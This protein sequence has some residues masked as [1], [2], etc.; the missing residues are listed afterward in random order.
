MNSPGNPNSEA[1]GVVREVRNAQRFD[2]AALAGY[3]K[4]RVDG[5]DDAVQVRQFDG[6][7]S[8]PTY[9][10]E[11]S[12]GSRWVMR[13]KPAGQL[14]ATAHMVERE[15]QITSVLA[16][17]AVP[18]AKPLLLCQDASII[19]TPFYLIEYVHGRIFRDPS[20][21]TLTSVEREAAYDSM[22]TTLATLH[23]VDWQAIGL[24]D[25]G[26]ADGYVAR[27]IVRWTKQYQASKLR[28]IAAM[29]WLIDWLPRHLPAQTSTGIVHGDFRIDNMIFHPTEPR[30]IAVVDWE[31]STIGDPLT[32][33]AYHC[34]AFYLR[35]E[36]RGIAG[37]IG[38]DLKV[39]GIPS[40]ADIVARY[41]AARGILSIPNWNFFIAFALFRLAAIAEGVYARMRQGNATTD[42]AASVAGES[43][44]FA[45]AARAAAESA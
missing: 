44:A 11:N 6:G 23:A 45:Q 10:L 4:G 7:Q 36:Q 15:Y 22:I 39:L 32:D 16:G 38:H 26:K 14:L 13:K 24:G 42:A 35:R 31:L 1:T 21:P 17:T 37:L 30:V 29:D 27:Q 20:L 28:D 41:C 25:Y 40:E 5:I 3:L 2:V 9:L 19:G 8:N 33:V 43:E 12:R 18:V 34:L